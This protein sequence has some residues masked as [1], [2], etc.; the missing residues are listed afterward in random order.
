MIA[1]YK[2]TSP[3]GRVYIGQSFDVE[4]R[5]RQYNRKNCKSQPTLYNSFIKHSVEAHSFEI[6]EQIDVDNQVYVNER[7]L[8]YWQRHIDSGCDMMN[9]KMPGNQCKFTEEHK[10]K[11]GDAQRGQ[12]RP[13]VG[14]KVKA[15]LTGRKLSE[16]HRKNISEGHKGIKKSKE[17]IEK[18]AAAHRGKKISL[19]QIESI[20]KSN[21]GRI[22]WNKGKKVGRTWNKGVKGYSTAWKGGKLSNE[23]KAKIGEKVKAA[24]ANGRYSKRNSFTVMAERI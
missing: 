23:T 20:R 15:A 2:I 14:V 18:T 10:K 17:S 19:E 7:E 4:R 11:I 16:E 13:T 1:I 5:F 22:P 9:L 8:H 6:L 21:T 24:W 12:K 3:T